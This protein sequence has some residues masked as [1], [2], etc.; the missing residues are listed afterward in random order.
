M[1]FQQ[2]QAVRGRLF[3]L[4][5]LL[6]FGFLLV[7][8]VLLTVVRHDYYRGRALKNRQVQFRVPSPRGRITD[9][10]GVPLAD[11]T[12]HSDITVAASQFADD[13]VDST[14]VR[15]ISWFDLPLDATLADL[16]NRCP[17][18]VA[19]AGRSWCAAPTWVG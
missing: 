3:R 15:L 4:L 7:I 8:L 2:A 12:F 13:E 10:D 6:L 16:R 1:E 5:A 9:R 14:L 11:N 19:T 18:A 17:R